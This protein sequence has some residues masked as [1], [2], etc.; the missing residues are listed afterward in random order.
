[1]SKK[2]K[3]TNLHKHRITL[4]LDMIDGEFDPHQIDWKKLL[5]M[6]PVERC[7]VYVENLDSL[8]SWKS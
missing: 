3:K 5:S 6:Q 7:E 1:M 4:T 2:F 8:P